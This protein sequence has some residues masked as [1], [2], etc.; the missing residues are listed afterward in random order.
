[1]GGCLGTLLPAV[2]TAKVCVKSDG[3][4]LNR[5]PR[6]RLNSVIHINAT[7]AVNRKTGRNDD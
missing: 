4:V 7:V 2:Q 6:L 1:M 5:P 3:Q